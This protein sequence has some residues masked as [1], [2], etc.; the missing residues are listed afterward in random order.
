MSQYSIIF[1]PVIGALVAQ[2]AKV[3]GALYHRQ[4]TWHVWKE[5]GGMP[6]AHAAFVFA[7]LTEVALLDGVA[8]TSFILA[9]VL[10]VVI[11]RDASGYRR[12]MDHHA[13]TLN[14]LIDELPAARQ[15]HYTTFDSTM[16]HTPWQITVGAVIG[17]LVAWLGLG[18]LG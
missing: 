9:L 5:Y 11:V 18:W 15:T 3:I 16:G 4:F 10:T 1:I 14:R 8:S 13:A 17:A 6:S 2:L 7:A 12:T